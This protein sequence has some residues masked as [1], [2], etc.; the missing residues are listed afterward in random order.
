MTTQKQLEANRRNAQKSTGPKT[1]EGK[2][3]ASQNSTTHGLTASSE[4]SRETS[5][6][7]NR[8]V[9]ASEDRGA[10][11]HFRDDMILEY[12]P[13]GPMEYILTERIVALAW[14]LR[15]S[16]RMQTQA[17]ETLINKAP[18]EPAAA[19][20]NQD[21]D[22]TQSADTPLGRITVDDF[23]DTR[24]IERLSIYEHRMERALFKTHLEL[25]RLQS[26]R[27][28]MNTLPKMNKRT[29]LKNQ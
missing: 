17:V 27:I 12:D 4:H 9:I 29:H 24:V 2:R 15:R 1:D 20:E 16:E 28:K 10:Y 8:V 13:I 21:S 18:N 14:R 23:A 6:A 26:D 7:G 11:E 22:A 5:R 25:Q 19:V 3:I